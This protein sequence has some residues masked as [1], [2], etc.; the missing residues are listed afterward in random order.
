M[1]AQAAE[2]WQ[3]SR[4]DVAEATTDSAPDGAQPGAPVLG[5]R[6]VD[7]IAPQDVADLVADLHGDGKARESI[8]KTV[9]ALAMVFDHAGVRPNPARDRWP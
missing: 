8:R 9:T 6:R 5:N 7:G 3:A 1:F 2:R 4:V